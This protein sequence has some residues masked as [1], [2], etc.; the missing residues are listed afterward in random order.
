MKAHFKCDV[1]EVV[2]H[3]EIKSSILVIF[4]A[5]PMNKKVITHHRANKTDFFQN[6]KKV[7]DSR[8][9]STWHKFRLKKL[10]LNN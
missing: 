10:N 3:I 9:C 8:L 5:L 7:Q 2:P 6:Q 1:C 4:P